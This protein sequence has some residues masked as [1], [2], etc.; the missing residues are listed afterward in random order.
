MKQNLALAACF[1]TC[2]TAFADQHP[3]EEVAP[4]YAHRI[5]FNLLR[6]GYEH[7]KLDAYYVGVECWYVL[8]F[9]SQDDLKPILGEAEARIGYNFSLNASNVFTPIVGCGYFKSF[10]SDK[11]QDI[12]F[13]S[14]GFRYEYVIGPIFSL[15]L[16]LEGMLGYSQDNR[17]P[18]WGN[19]IWGVDAGLPFTWRFAKTRRW[20]FRFEPFFTKWYGQN[21]EVFFVGARSA[22]GYR[23]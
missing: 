6:L 10:Q 11:R 16:N 23:F 20:D 12:V 21:T 2:I 22:L 3:S 1:L 17:H 5:N 19:P 18:S 14:M 15:G 4:S 9:N 7:I 13:S 8:G